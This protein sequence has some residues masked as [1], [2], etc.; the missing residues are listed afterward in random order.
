VTDL[1]FDL[2]TFC[3]LPGGSDYRQFDTKAEA[4]PWWLRIAAVYKD[5]RVIDDFHG[6]QAVALMPPL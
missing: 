6:L 1:D 4:G 5:L 3:I 2:R